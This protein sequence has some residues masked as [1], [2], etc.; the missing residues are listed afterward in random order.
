MSSFSTALAS[1]IAAQGF[2]QAELAQAAGITQSRVSNYVLGKVE[3]TAGTIEQI[4]KALRVEFWCN[5]PKWGFIRNS[6][7][8]K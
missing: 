5:G 3:P 1:A 6:H 8:I 2:T 4:S 7:N